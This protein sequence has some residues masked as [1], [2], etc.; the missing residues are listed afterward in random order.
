MSAEKFQESPIIFGDFMKMGADQADRIYEALTDM[1]K[2][3]NISTWVSTY[4]SLKIK[5]SHHQPQHRIAF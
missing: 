5:S 1:K 4:P 3:S 2:V